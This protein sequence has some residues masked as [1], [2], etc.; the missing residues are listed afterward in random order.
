MASKE[1]M[2]EQQADDSLTSEALPY[3]MIIAAS[4]I[5]ASNH[6]LA[7]QL[8]DTIP[9]MGMVF[10]RMA[11][12]ALV[13]LPVAGPALFANRALVIHHWKL[14]VLMGLLFVPLGN[15]LIYLGYH[16][17]TAMN[18]GVVTTSQPGMTVLLAWLLFRD[19]ISWKQGLGLFLAAIG[20]LIILAQ[21]DPATLLQFKLNIGDLVLLLATLAVALHNVVLRNVPREISI[22]QLVLLVQLVGLTITLPVYVAESIYYRPVPVTWEA[23][24]VLVWIG[25]AV[26]T[27]AVSMTNAA[28]RLIGA[29]KAS[30]ANYIRSAATVILAILILGET[31]EIHHAIALAL[32]IGG[33]YLMTQG[34]K[35]AAQQPAKEAAD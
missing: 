23:V 27:I 18:G 5:I 32:V 28:V 9:P 30:M 11:I 20:V 19:F 21:G 10:W 15:G 25:V 8:G 2:S 6:I 33:V 34:R 12:G 24:G 26:T 7:R 17:T 3:A 4:F 29:T 31:F 22:R 35:L 14:F 13:L 1:Q 16:F